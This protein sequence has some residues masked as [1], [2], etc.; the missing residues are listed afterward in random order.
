MIDGSKSVFKVNI[1]KIYVLVCE[2]SIFKGTDNN[3]ELSSSVA[4][5]TKAFMAVM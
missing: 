5:S 3:L 4:F 1:K 2:F